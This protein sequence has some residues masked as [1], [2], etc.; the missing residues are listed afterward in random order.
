[1]MN[2]GISVVI[3][4]TLPDMGIKSLG[5][6]S[7][8]KIKNKYFIEYQIEAI[9]RALKT[10]DHEI[11]VASHFDYNKTHKFISSYKK[12]N[13]ISVIKQA[14]DN[15]NYGGAMLDALSKTNF[16]NVL[17]LNYGCWFNKDTIKAMVANTSKNTLGV[18]KSKQ[19]DNLSV[20]CLI[21]DN[22]IENMF[23]DISDNKFTEMF[24]I[25]Q[26]T[27]K[28]ILS[29]FLLEDN[30]NKFIFEIINALI[31]KNII[32]E[33]QPINAKDYVFLTSNR[34]FKRTR[35]FINESASKTQR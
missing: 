25:N 4:S 7:L 6:K 10:I 13:N 8:I 27:K 32:F 18:I 28:Y 20:S 21:K 15:I 33:P 19:I 34:H 35:R 5:T 2:N 17:F 30:I 3:L 14:F 24:F 1:M 26:D 29:N 9:N 11:V 16:D 31:E 12:E 22:T 23:F